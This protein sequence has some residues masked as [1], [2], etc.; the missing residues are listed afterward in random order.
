[1]EVRGFLDKVD[2]VDMAQEIIS[3]LSIEM[4]TEINFSRNPENKSSLRSK[5]KHKLSE[6]DEESTGPSASEDSPE[7]QSGVA[8][9]SESS[10]TDSE[11]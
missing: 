6:R 1:M 11:D 2:I 3:G 7:K 8:A 5:V 9:D 4:K 10:T